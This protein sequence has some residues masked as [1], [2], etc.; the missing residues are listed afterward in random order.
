[1]SIAPAENWEGIDG[2]WNTFALRVGNPSQVVRVYISTTSQQT[3]VVAP[4]GCS[5]WNQTECDSRRGSDF[6]SNSS[7]SWT[8]QGTY[9]LWIESNLG[10]DGTQ[11]IGIYGYDTVGL[12]YQG[13]GGPTL[14]KQIVGTLSTYDFFYGHFG[15]SPKP[16]NWTDFNDPYPSYLTSLKNESQIPSLSWAYTAGAQY[17]KLQPNDLDVELSAEHN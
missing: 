16:T 3:W 11:D 6:S 5:G 4:I 9:K 8:D 13:E 2:Q 14:E 15:L 7:S 1:L 12:G 17:S 10:F